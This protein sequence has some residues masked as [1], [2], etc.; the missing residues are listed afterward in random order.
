MD[1]QGKNS[2]PCVIQASAGLDAKAAPPRVPGSSVLPSQDA[3]VTFFLVAWS[4][5]LPA[6]TLPQALVQVDD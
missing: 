1:L 4:A 5:S 3:D 2:A 6:R